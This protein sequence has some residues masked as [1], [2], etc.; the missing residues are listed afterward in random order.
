MDALNHP[1]S[2]NVYREVHFIFLFFFPAE[3]FWIIQTDPYITF[4]FISIPQHLKA[5]FT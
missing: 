4:I 1:R 5:Q 2:R 3:Y